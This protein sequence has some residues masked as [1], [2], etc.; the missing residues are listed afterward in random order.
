MKLMFELVVFLDWVVLPSVR[1]N[2]SCFISSFSVWNLLVG[3]FESNSSSYS[4]SNNK[5]PSSNSFCEFTLFLEKVDTMKL[6]SSKSPAWDNKLSLMEPKRSKILSL[7]VWWSI[8]SSCLWTSSFVDFVTMIGSRN[9]L[10]GLTNLNRMFFGLK[11]LYGYILGRAAL[12]SWR[13]SSKPT[14]AH[15]SLFAALKSFSVAALSSSLT[16][17][18]K[19]L[20]SSLCDGDSKTIVL[21]PRG[22]ISCAW[23]Q[24][25][26]SYHTSYV[27]LLRWSSFTIPQVSTIYCNRCVIGNL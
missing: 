7:C 9:S 11:N 8:L 18:L 2:G 19:V 1:E 16:A 5:F 13:K 21:F 10:S 14:F 23:N 20:F 15:A 26:R 25:N 3:W 12:N 27:K 17:S 24:A 22:P 6:L 4:W